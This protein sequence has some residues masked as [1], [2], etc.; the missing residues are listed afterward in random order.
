MNH[1]TFQRKLTKEVFPNKKSDL[2]T[3]ENVEIDKERLTWSLTSYA[4]GRKMDCT[5]ISRQ[6]ALSL[7]K[8]FACVFF[9]FA[10]PSNVISGHIISR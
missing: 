4:P 7:R 2:F 1:V 3:R 6:D 8:E 10:L 9:F 5:L